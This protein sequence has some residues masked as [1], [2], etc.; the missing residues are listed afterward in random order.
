MRLAIGR[1]KKCQAYLAAY[2]SKKP[3]CLLQKFGRVWLACMKV[4]MTFKLSNWPI[5]VNV[6]IAILEEVLG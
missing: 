6:T 4:N 3:D 2:A 1:Q 5:Q